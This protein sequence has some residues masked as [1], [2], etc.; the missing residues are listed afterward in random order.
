MGASRR[1]RRRGSGGGLFSPSVLRTLKAGTRLASGLLT[2]KRTPKR[3][4][5]EKT[6]RKSK[7]KSGRNL[8]L[9]IG[10]HEAKNVFFTQRWRSKR[11]PKMYK[12]LGNP[13]TVD[14][15]EYGGL[16]HGYGE[17]G[18]LLVQR[19]LSTPHVNVLW[20]HLV[21]QQVNI[22]APS[23]G[24]GVPFY[25]ELNKT[26]LSV[27][28]GNQNR[29]ISNKF[30]LEQVSSEIRFMNQAPS[31][32]ELEIYYCQSRVTSN[33][34][35]GATAAW[36]RAIDAEAGESLSSDVTNN[37][38]NQP[39]TRPTSRKL[40]NIS[41]KVVKKISLTLEA[42]RELISTY[43]FK[44]MAIMDTQYW[45]QYEQVKGMTHDVFIVQRG[46]IG[47]DLNQ[48]TVGQVTTTPTKV[49]WTQRVKTKISMISDNSRKY[50]QV[51]ALPE[52]GVS[53]LYI[54]D[55]EDP[56]VIDTELPANYA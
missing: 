49:I 51:G 1:S 3:A 56:R 38:I 53:N 55:T 23:I 24:G 32:V 6:K 47:D 27:G 2:P 20:D 9:N 16:T 50:H 25:A 30:L 17:Q 35:V 34:V 48:K 14:M 8:N 18:V 15:L 28:T 46:V 10:N 29:S 41:W 21:T 11:I 12:A 7:E 36:Q 5:R 54:Q 33:A 22:M 43:V 31:T 42:G 39:Y 19:F 26:P 40:F 45:A 13:C 4:K 37:G 52:S 44:P